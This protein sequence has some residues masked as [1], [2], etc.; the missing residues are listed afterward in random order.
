MNPMPLE[1]L[2]MSELTL[3][4]EQLFASVDGRVFACLVMLH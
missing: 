2:A 4:Q 3:F 1:L